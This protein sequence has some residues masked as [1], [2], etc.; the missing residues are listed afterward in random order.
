MAHFIFLNPLFANNI[1][2]TEKMSNIFLTKL[3]R[4][5]NEYFVLMTSNMAAL[6]LKR[7]NQQNMKTWALSLLKPFDN[8]SRESILQEENS[9]V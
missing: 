5:K 8:K 2:S 3:L 1:I 6:I 7:S 4:K 9:T